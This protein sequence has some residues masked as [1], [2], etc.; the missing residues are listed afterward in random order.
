[1]YLSALN[2]VYG[3]LQWLK[4][5]CQHRRWPDWT[6]NVHLVSRRISRPEARLIEEINR[7]HPYL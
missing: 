4:Y 7:L 5:P 1:M 6:W 3:V 2:G